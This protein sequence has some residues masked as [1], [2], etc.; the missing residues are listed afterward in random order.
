M[1]LGVPCA[2]NPKHC[3]FHQL[4]LFQ[5]LLSL[6]N[7]FQTLLLFVFL[8]HHFKQCLLLSH[9]KNRLDPHYYTTVL[10]K[11]KPWCQWLDNCLYFYGRLS[12]SNIWLAQTAHPEPSL[13]FYRR[14]SLPKELSSF[15]NTSCLLLNQKNLTHHQLIPVGY[16]PKLVHL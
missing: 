13:N 7:H 6:F 12:A 4:F 11:K 8:F 2:L 16:P 9:P 15:R 10:Q 5:S 3:C 14:C 1:Q